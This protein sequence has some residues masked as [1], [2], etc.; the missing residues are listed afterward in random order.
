M[1]LPEEQDLP[2][3]IN[4]VPMIDVIFAILAFL[5][6]STL[7]L[8]R[9]EGLPVNL[10]SAV[11]AQ[12]QNTE[13][14]N[15]TIQA[16]GK[17]Y[18]NRQPLELSELATAVRQLMPS[19]SPILVLVNADA[20]VSHGQVVTVMDRLRQIEGVKLAIAVEEKQKSRE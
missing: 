7:F 11:T 8:T 5:I 2:L 9:S 20:E 18:L 19:E 16:D 14:I 17:I 1:R 10:P 6:I 15:V 3:S 4:I 12:T 13:K